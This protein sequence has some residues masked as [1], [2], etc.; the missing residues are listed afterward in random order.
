MGNDDRRVDPRGESRVLDD[1]KR[2]LYYTV[3]FRAVG[4]GGFL[5]DA[6]LFEHR[7]KLTTEKLPPVVRPYYLNFRRHSVSARAAKNFLNAYPESDLCF[8]N[9]THAWRE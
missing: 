4:V 6:M 9:Y 5:L 2:S 3:L 7:S 1:T 8:R